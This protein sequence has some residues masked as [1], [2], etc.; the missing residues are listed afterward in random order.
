ML[1]SE[2]ASAFDE[3]MRHDPE[4]RSAFREMDRLASAVAVTATIPIA[5]RAGQLERLHLRLGLSPQKR[6][7]WLGISGW[8]AAACLALLLVIDRNSFSP[9]RPADSVAKSSEVRLDEKVAAAAEQR[10]IS[11]KL[12]QSNLAPVIDDSIPQATEHGSDGSV[13]VKVETKRLIQEI[14]VL[15]EKLETVE[16]RDR[17][18][19]EP[20]PGM[21]WPIVMRM[22]PPATSGSIVGPLA[23]NAEERTLTE[24][25]VDALAS[26]S[27]TAAG[28]NHRGMQPSAPR[29]ADTGASGIPIYDPTQGQGTLMVENLPE[30]AADQDYHLWVQTEQNGKPLRVG[31]L[32]EFSNVGANSFDFSLGAR[33]VIPTAFILTKGNNSNPAVPSD[34]NTVLRGPN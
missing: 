22:L 2:E 4:L 5:P 3:T 12:Q 7:N 9:S 20:K 29:T 10:V 8:A 18:R 30:K 34:S 11:E 24:E 26:S 6:P 16:Q 27:M 15:R 21:A 19:F 33:G 13:V 23:S 17:Q 1:D 32:P 31:K 25:I 28:A 14:E